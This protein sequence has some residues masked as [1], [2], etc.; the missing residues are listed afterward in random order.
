MCHQIRTEFLSGIG[1]LDLV[2]MH[3]QHFGVR[4]AI[5]DPDA[6]V[7]S[8]PKG[9]RGALPAR[10]QRARHA[11]TRTCPNWLVVARWKSLR[12]HDSDIPGLEQET[13]ASVLHVLL[14]DDG[15]VF[16]D[17]DCWHGSSCSTGPHFRSSRFLAWIFVHALET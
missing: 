12:R 9:R 14:E 10:K 3:S 7:F 1:L 8:T 5:K 11:A 16:L 4:D 6:D 13:A 17:R 2:E 15:T